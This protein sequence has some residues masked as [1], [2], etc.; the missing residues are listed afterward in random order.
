MNE[1]SGVDAA[2]L[3]EIFQTIY[4]KIDDKP[5]RPTEDKADLKAE[6]KEIEAAAQADPAQIDES[7]LAHR[8]R[9]IERMAPDIIDV[10]GA[11]VVNPVAGVGVVWT[12][13][14][15]KAEEIKAAR[16]QKAQSG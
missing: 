11:T 7:F 10:I 12:K 4:G 3:A 2:K 15:A 1:T 13:I 14:K 9:N 16:E 5:N 6:I 8:L